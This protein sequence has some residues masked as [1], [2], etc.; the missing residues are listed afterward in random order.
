MRRE[1]NKKET[2]LGQ[3]RYMTRTKGDRTR[4]RRRQDK[5]KIGQDQKRRQ[6]MDKRRQDKNKKKSLYSVFTPDFRNIS[7]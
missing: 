2:R 7:S 6:D 5:D 1:K 3:E 4:T